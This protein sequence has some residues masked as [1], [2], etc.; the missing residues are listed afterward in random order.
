MTPR[1]FIL[2]AQCQPFGGGVNV[3]M[4]AEDMKP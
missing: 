1:I 3:V 2:A 4:T